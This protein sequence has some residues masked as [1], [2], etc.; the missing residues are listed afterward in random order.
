MS[1]DYGMQMTVKSHFCY[2]PAHEQSN[3]GAMG[4]VFEQLLAA[5]HDW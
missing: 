4:E 2:L 3:A 1:P 5:P